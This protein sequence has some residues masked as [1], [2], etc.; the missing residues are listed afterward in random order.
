VRSTLF[1]NLMNVALMKL[2]RTIPNASATRSGR[3]IEHLEHRLPGRVVGPGLTQEIQPWIGTELREI[4]K[5]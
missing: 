5:R 1:S 3:S 2:Q 4:G